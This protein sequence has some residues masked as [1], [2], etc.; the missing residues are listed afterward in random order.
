MTLN[1]RYGLNC[2]NDASFGAQYKSF[3]E[4]RP[5]LSAVRW[6]TKWSGA[7]KIGNFYRMQHHI[8]NILSSNDTKTDDFKRCGYLMLEIFIGHVCETHTYAALSE[9]IVSI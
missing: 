6:A 5:I 8:A 2:R 9:L 7:A 3:N 4:C 1:G